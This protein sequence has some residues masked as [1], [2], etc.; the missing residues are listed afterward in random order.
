MSWC[1]ASHFPEAKL[2]C[3]YPDRVSL[4]PNDAGM[5]N[6]VLDCPDPGVPD[7]AG[8]FHGDPDATG[9]PT[10]K[11]ADDGGC[12]CNTAGGSGGQ[13]PALLLLRLV[14]VFTSRCSRRR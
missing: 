1:A 3:P 2:C 5:A 10:A 6:V 13:P 14:L 9:A 7:D 8:P 12:S 11:S 4:D